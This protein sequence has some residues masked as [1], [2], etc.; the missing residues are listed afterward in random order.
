MA[1]LDTSKESHRQDFHKG[2]KQNRSVKQ[3]ELDLKFKYEKL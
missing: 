2:L 1:V 3:Q